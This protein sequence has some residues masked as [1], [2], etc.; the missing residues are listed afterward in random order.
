[1]P[2]TPSAPLA[3]PRTPS[4]GSNP[5]VGKEVD[6]YYKKK[7]YWIKHCPKKAE[8]SVNNIDATCDNEYGDYDKEQAETESENELA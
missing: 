6:E 3:A 7:G 1:V 4:A 8:A 2:T 5:L